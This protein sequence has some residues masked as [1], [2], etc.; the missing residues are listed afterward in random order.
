MILKTPS[1]KPIFLVRPETEAPLP[2]PPPT[3]HAAL[4]YIEGLLLL[5]L[6]G[7]PAPN[8]MELQDARKREKKRMEILEL[9]RRRLHVQRLITDFGGVLP[10]RPLPLP[11]ISVLFVYISRIACVIPQD[12]LPS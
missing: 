11:D 8:T 4:S 3:P 7:D 12:V 5:S 1:Q 2:P 6:Q 10:E 9:E